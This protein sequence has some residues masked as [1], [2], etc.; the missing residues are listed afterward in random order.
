MINNYIILQ[1]PLFIF[2]KTCY[3]VRNLKKK[4]KPF[5]QTHSKRLNL[6]LFLINPNFIA[7]SYHYITKSNFNFQFNN[8]NNKFSI[9]FTNFFFSYNIFSLL[10]SFLQVFLYLFLQNILLT[11]INQFLV[12]SNKL[13]YRLYDLK[14]SQNEQ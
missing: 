8:A 12:V 4:T 9:E 1:S 7:I 11:N 13:I 3:I 2:R 10:I 6:S 5:I 14:L